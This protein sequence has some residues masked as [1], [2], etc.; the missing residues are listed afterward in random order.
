MTGIHLIINKFTSNAN[1]LVT[2]SKK[3]VNYFAGGVWNMQQ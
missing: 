3:Y 1:P 2:Q